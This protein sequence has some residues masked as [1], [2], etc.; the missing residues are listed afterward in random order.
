[1]DSLSPACKASILAHGACANHRTDISLASN[2]QRMALGRGACL[3]HLPADFPQLMCHA[4]ILGT[5]CCSRIPHCDNDEAI[6][7]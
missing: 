3:T 7:D 4:I 6:E 2:W 1:M 5:S